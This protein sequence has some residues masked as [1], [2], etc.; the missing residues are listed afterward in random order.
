MMVIIIT[1]NKTVWATINKKKTN[2]NSPPGVNRD[3]SSLNLLSHS[4]GIF[5]ACP[6]TTC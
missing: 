2:H 4:D 6:I 3:T 1:D 5:H